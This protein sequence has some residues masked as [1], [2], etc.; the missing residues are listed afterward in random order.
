MAA[1]ITQPGGVGTPIFYM[2]NA[3]TSGG[4]ASGPYTYDQF[5]AAFPADFI[6]NSGTGKRAFRSKVDVLMGD[7]SDNWPV[8]TLQE[9]AG[10]T[11]EFD[12]GKGLGYRVDSGTTGR[13]I[14]WNTNL[15]IKHGSGT[16]GSGIGGGRISCS[17][18]NISIGGY[19]YTSGIGNTR[20]YGF[21]LIPTSGVY[22]FAVERVSSGQP[23]FLEMMQSSI[24]NMGG[25]AVAIG[26]ID[27][28]GFTLYNVQ[29]GGTTTTAPIVTQIKVAH[30]D[31][32]TI[33]G[34]GTYFIQ[35]GNPNL[36]IR[37]MKLFGVPVN[38]DIRISNQFTVDWYFISPRFSGSGKPRFS[39]LNALTM[40]DPDHAAHHYRRCESTVRDSS[41][42]PMDG[43]SYQLIDALGNMAVDALTDSN[44]RVAFG[45]EPFDNAVVVC[46]H[47]NLPVGGVAT[48]AIR[49][50]GP[51]TRKVNDPSSPNYNSAYES[52]SELLQWPGYETMTTVSGDFLDMNDTIILS[53]PAAPAAPPSPILVDDVPLPAEGEIRYDM[54]LPKEAN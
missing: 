18:R 23:F 24:Q 10:A 45:S 35:F 26:A 9:T 31:D 4:R 6:N 3:D 30:C 33:S 50:R 1:G 20:F 14:N 32:L 48:Y 51:F 21:T 34:N 36:I 43:V 13:E 47:Y 42:S 8:S 44:G 28:P 53:P 5:A 52:K 19:T 46:D 49:H 37:G 38:A 16:I 11:L 15:G 12:A 29:V 7:T 54:A 2:D 25:T 39:F 22:G 40:L 27:E 17:P 41:G